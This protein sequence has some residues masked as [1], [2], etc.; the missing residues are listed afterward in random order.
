MLVALP[1]DGSVTLQT[2]CLFV[3]GNSLDRVLAQGAELEL[4]E[5]AV[6][7]GFGARGIAVRQG[8]TFVYAAIDQH[9]GDG[10]R[11]YADQAKQRPG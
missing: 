10:E 2:T 3:A 4:V 7:R 8:E 11:R 6:E 1:S 5:D 9:A